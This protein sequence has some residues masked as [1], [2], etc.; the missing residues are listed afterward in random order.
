MHVHDIVNLL[1]NELDISLNCRE[2][3]NALGIPAADRDS[4]YA[5]RST[6]THYDLWWEIITAWI[7]CK[8]KRFATKHQLSV[9]LREEGWAD[10]AG[11]SLK[12]ENLQ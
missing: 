9:I 10:A 2:V 5:K 12:E 7:Q 1:K 4:I 11:M 3:C 6:S 8:G